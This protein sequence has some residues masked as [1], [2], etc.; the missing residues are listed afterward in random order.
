MTSQI[1]RVEANV[2]NS[3]ISLVRMGSRVSLSESVTLKH[4]KQ[5]SFACIVKSQEDNV[6]VLLKESCP[7]KYAFEEVND[8]HFVSSD[9]LKL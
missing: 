3:D 6:G 4:V 7:L 8:E 5:S 2:S 1:V 9:Y